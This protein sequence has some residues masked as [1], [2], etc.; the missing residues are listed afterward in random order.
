MAK[1]TFTV[2]N[3]L[4]QDTSQNVLVFTVPTQAN[5]NYTFAAW[6]NLNISPNGGS[7]PFDFDINLSVIAEDQN[8]GTR[9]AP[10]PVKAN[11]VLLATYENLRGISLVPAVSNADVSR[12]TAQQSGVINATD[13]KG[14]KA[15]LL[16]TEWYIN[17]R[18][19]VRVS[20]MNASA[21]ATFELQPSLYFFA[22]A[23]TVTGFNYTYQLVSQQTKYVIPNPDQTPAVDVKWTR[24]GDMAGADQF[25]FSPPSA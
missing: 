25:L 16:A 21:I 8:T 4:P 24:G 17:G 23:P 20:N 14:G 6:Q 13:R 15:I 10:T 5:P 12:I 7:Q 1:T 2:T 22:A 3:T 19:A 11:Q 18:A 9:S